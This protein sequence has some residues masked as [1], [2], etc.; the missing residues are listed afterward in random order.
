VIESSV[1]GL[2]IIFEHRNYLPSMMAVL[3]ALVLIFPVLSHPS[4]K[5]VFLCIVMLLFSFWTFERNKVW[6][7]KITLWSDC[8]AKS[9]NKARPHNNLGVALKKEGR[10]HEAIEHFKQTIAIDP[11]FTEAYNNLGNSYMKIARS[12]EAIKQYKMALSLA[13][14]DPR[15][16]MNIGH[17]L[18]K[19]WQ[20]EEALL[21]YGEAFRLNPDE[22]AQLNFLSTQ[23]M[24]NTR[25]SKAKQ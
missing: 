25:K 17:A 22:E 6:T 2:E 21:H 19:R 10:V 13:P 8:A 4:L 18:V 7:D 12:E 20:L 14:E 1:I 23:R 9:P 11:Q 24:I 15:I 16:H 3:L 5:V